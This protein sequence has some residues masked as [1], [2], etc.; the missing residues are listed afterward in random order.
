MSIDAVTPLRRRMIEDMNA[1]A[2]CANAEGPHSQ[3]NRSPNHASKTSIS[4]S[5][6]GTSSGQSSVIV[7]ILRSRFACRRLG[8]AWAMTS[9]RR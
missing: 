2:L 3:L 4:A 6:T 1:Q 9:A 5:V 8:R 7:H